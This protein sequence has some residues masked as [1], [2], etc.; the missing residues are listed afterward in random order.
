MS[1]VDVDTVDAILDWVHANGFRTT[2]YSRE[3]YLDCSGELAEWQTEI[4]FPIAPD[5]DR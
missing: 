3:N 2:G 5:P 4:Q 1:T